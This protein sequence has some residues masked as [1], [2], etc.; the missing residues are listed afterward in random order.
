M[1][2]S[3]K[4]HLELQIKHFKMLIETQIDRNTI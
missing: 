3:I 4:R 1:D 2:P